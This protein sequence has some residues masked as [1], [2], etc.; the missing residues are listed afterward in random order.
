MS[1][2]GASSAAAGAG[3]AAAG[4]GSAAAGAPSA[5]AGA[6]SVIL[7]G[8]APPAVAA[9]PAGGSFPGAGFHVLETGEIWCS[10][11]DRVLHGP[12]QLQDHKIGKYHKKNLRAHSAAVAVDV[13]ARAAAAD[14]NLPPGPPQ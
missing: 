10:L 11:C 13:L 12:T 14:A 4:A 7:D 2:A 1:D 8:P 6:G 3:S 5:A 9:E